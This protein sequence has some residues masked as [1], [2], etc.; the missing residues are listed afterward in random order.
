MVSGF[1]RGIL[2]A[3]CW[4][5]LTEGKL[6]DLWLGGLIAFLAAASSYL[7]LPSRFLTRFR[8]AGVLHFI[9]F[10]LVQSVRG[11]LDVAWRALHPSLPVQP[12][13][14]TEPLHLS[15]EGLRILYAWTVSLLPGTASVQLTDDALTVHMLTRTPATEK[16]LNRLEDVIRGLSQFAEPE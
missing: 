3:G 15:D 10:F 16:D 11:G 13:M 8:A 5:L 6:M 9:L 7:V 14:V 4:V 1:L 2:F 12:V